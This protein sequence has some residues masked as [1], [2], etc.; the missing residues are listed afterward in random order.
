MVICV[1]RDEY[2]GIKIFLNLGVFFGDIAH[3]N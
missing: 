2:F 3:K 1:E